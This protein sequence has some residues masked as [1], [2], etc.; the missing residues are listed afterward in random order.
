MP[1]LAPTPLPT[2]MATGVARPSAQGQLMTSTEMPR[3]TAKAS[4]MPSASHTAKV[5]AAMPMTAGTNTAA[6][7]SAVLASGALV[8]AA[9]RTSRMTWE[10]VVS[11][12]TRVARQVSAPFWLMVAALTVEPGNLSTGMLSPVR[13]A[14]F[15]ED[16]P[17]ATVPS[18]GMLSP[19]RTRNRSPTFTSATGTCTCFPSRSRQAVWGVRSIR[20]FSA[21]VVR[22]L[23]RASS[24]LPTVMRVRIMAADSKYKSW[25]YCITSASSPVDSPAP[26]MPMANNPYTSAAPAPSATSVS[27]PG[28]RVRRPFQPETKKSRLMRHTGRVSASW[29]SPYHSAPA[30]WPSRRA[31]SGRPAMCPIVR[32][33][34]G[35]RKHRL[36]VRRFFRRGVSVSA[37]AA[38]KPASG[39]AR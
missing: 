5:T 7:R 1:F 18:T 27:M 34:S 36:A 38:C 26:I 13:A 37:S 19:G 3:A 21:S 15:T 10:R 30:P 16:T 11:C 33:I 22:P 6:T 29:A 25:R 14:S 31:G 20:L 24:S 9:S 8:A 4:P 35:T 39:S 2:M 12:P 32:Y 23:E 17:S 28:A